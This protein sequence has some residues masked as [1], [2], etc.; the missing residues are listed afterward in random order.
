ML[1]AYQY[2]CIIRDCALDMPS[3]ADWSWSI[4][5]CIWFR[6]VGCRRRDAQPN[7]GQQIRACMRSHSRARFFELCR[8]TFWQ[9]AEIICQCSDR[10]RFSLQEL[11]NPGSGRPGFQIH[12]AQCVILLNPQLFS[13]RTK[14]L[15]FKYDGFACCRLYTA[16]PFFVEAWVSYVDHP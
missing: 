12:C 9:P 14:A 1:P 3:T 8:T 16:N 11:S 7:G 5:N 2:P 6:I 15:S 10:Y 4:P 13:N